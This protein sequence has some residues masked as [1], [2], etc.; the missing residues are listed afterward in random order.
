M[1]NKKINILLIVVTV[2]FFIGLFFA[3]DKLNC[4]VTNYKLRN[5]DVE[6]NKTDSVTF[7][8]QFNN[9]SNTYLF[10][11]SLIELGGY[12][13]KPCMKMDTVLQKIKTIYKD[14]VNIKTFR[15]TTDKGK[16]I[17]KYFGVNTIPTQIIFDINGNEVYRHTGFLSKH[18]LET[19]IKSIIE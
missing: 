13:C 14:E 4:F 6:I 7:F 8:E 11:L 16:L 17:A 1:K 5:N 12:G 15:V 18:D 10:K 3:K 2:I 19:K 9:S